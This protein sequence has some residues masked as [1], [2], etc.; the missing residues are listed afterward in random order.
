MFLASCFVCLVVFHGQYLNTHPG[1]VDLIVDE[2]GGDATEAFEDI[3]HGKEAREILA[4]HIIG[5]VPDYDPEKF[6]AAKVSCA[7]AFAV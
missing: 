4:Q 6:A 7:L 1:G 2:A 3:G 5:Y